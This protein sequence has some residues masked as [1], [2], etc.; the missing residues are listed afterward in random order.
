[1][2]RSLLL[3]DLIALICVDRELKLEQYQLSK[4]EW[5]IIKQLVPIFD[6]FIYLTNFMLQNK[7]PLI[8]EVILMFD[9]LQRLFDITRANSN[10]HPIVRYAVIIANVVRNKYYSL[11]H[12]RSC[13]A[14]QWVRALL[15]LPHPRMKLNYFRRLGWKSDWIEMAE[16]LTR[17]ICERDYKKLDEAGQAAVAAE[18]AKKKKKKVCLIVGFILI[19]N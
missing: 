16:E 4:T 5:Q 8:Y 1:M 2:L 6:M 3:R 13:I 18:D 10:L 9:K 14:L 15:F 17:T 12:S 19:I 7:I 11:T